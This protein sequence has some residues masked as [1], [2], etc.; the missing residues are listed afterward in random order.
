MPRRVPPSGAW[1]PNHGLWTSWPGCWGVWAVGLFR[2][3]GCGGPPRAAGLQPGAPQALQTGWHLYAIKRHG[4]PIWATHQ[5]PKAW[6][7][8][9]FPTW[10]VNCHR[11]GSR[12]TATHRCR[13]RPL[14]SLSAT[15]A[16][17]TRP[18]IGSLAIPQLIVSM[19]FVHRL[20]GNINREPFE[21][22]GLARSTLA[23]DLDS[24]GFL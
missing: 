4:V 3:F 7:R 17:A 5:S 13:W 15:K 16:L 23:I 8:K 18:P 6:L 1:P 22:K 19:V 2:R 24:Y 21:I 10:P 20:S 14:S 12:V 11:I 9:F